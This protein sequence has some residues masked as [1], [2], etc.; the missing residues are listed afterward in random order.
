MVYHLHLVAVLINTYGYVNANEAN[1][2]CCPCNTE[3]TETLIPSFVGNDYYC[4]SGTSGGWNLVL[5]PDDL[6]WDGQQC[7]GL[8]G[9][10][11]RLGVK[12]ISIC[13]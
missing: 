10:C 11:C 9:P 13:I 3:C 6:L 7:G 4:E 2:W 8:E 5:Y 12:Y 1:Y